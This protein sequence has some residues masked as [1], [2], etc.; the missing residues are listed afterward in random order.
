[1]FLTTG[2]CFSTNW[3]HKASLSIL[4]AVL[5]IAPSVVLADDD[6]DTGPSLTVP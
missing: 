5:C 4:L 1:M 3:I 2:R 6:S